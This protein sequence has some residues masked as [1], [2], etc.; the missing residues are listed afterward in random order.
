MLKTEVRVLEPKDRHEPDREV[1]I[2]DST[3]NCI[4]RFYF[5][6]RYGDLRENF[7]SIEGPRDMY[8]E[9]YLEVVRKVPVAVWHRASRALLVV[10]EVSSQEGEEAGK[11]TR[12]YAHIAEEYRRN[13]A[14]GLRD[15]AAEIARSHKVKPAT[16]RAW[17]RRAR[18]RGLLGHALGPLPGEEFPG[19]GH[20]S[21]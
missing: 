18:Q 7:Y 14:K 21:E 4:G 19:F 5:T 16:A 6:V 20:P 11:E 12:R 2:E 8:G 10:E 9:E 1:R 17:V 3:L 15:P 13:V